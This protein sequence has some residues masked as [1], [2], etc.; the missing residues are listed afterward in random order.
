MGMTSCESA[1]LSNRCRPM[2]QWISSQ[3]VLLPATAVQNARCRDNKQLLQLFESA[4]WAI[5]HHIDRKA[6]ERNG[7]NSNVWTPA[8]WPL[9]ACEN[10]GAF[11]ADFI[12]TSPYPKSASRVKM[13]QWLIQE[14]RASIV[15][16]F[17]TVKTIISTRIKID[18]EIRL[19]Q[20]HSP[21][22]TRPRMRWWNIVPSIMLFL[23]LELDNDFW[24]F[25]ASQMYVE[26]IGN[27][28]G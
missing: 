15:C 2:V 23:K 20:L 7:K 26:A 6:K 9:L 10:N 24:R 13:L 16:L 4:S 27:S 28:S 8:P 14:I 11:T 18:K 5:V 25:T 1:I 22:P 12:V 19:E 21:V 17:V 3:S